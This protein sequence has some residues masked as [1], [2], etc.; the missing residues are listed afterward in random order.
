MAEINLTPAVVIWAILAI[1]TLGLALYRKLIS[2]REQDLIHLGPGEERQ[3]PEQVALAERLKTVDRWG[4]TLTVVTVFV[5]LVMAA[6]YLYQA[7][8]IH[9]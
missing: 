1:A 3:I 7:F 5:G 6:V 9:K 8:L 4:K 2:A